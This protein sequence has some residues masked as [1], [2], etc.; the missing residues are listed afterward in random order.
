MNASATLSSA[1][2]L[3]TSMSPCATSPSP[4]FDV[5][6]AYLQGKFE[7]DDGERHVR[8]PPDERFFDDRGVPI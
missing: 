2:I 8:P 1:P 6:A 4:Q 3:R 5:E 7:G